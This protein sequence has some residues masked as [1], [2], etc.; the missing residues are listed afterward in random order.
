MRLTSPRE[1][2]RIFLRGVP[3]DRGDGRV[4]PST[5][6]APAAGFQHDAFDESRAGHLHPRRAPRRRDDRR[7]SKPCAADDVTGCERACDAGD[8]RQLPEP[9]LALRSRHR[10]AA[11][12]RRPR[13]V[14]FRPRVR[15]RRRAGLRESRTDVRAT[16]AAWAQRCKARAASL[17]RARVQRGQR[18]GVHEPWGHLRLRPRRRE[19]RGARRSRAM[20]RGC[21]GGHA[22]GC[23]NLGVMTSSAAS[24]WGR[25]RRAPS[26][27][28]RRACDGG[29][30]AG[31]TNLGRMCERGAGDLLCRSCARRGALPPVAASAATPTGAR[32]RRAEPRGDSSGPMQ[33]VTARLRAF[34]NTPG[35][36][37]ALASVGR[38]SKCTPSV[39][40]IGGA[41][42]A[43]HSPRR[44]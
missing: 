1:R 7:Y 10:P 41:R 25:T 23:A 2:G 5:S 37:R 36:P 19:R 33:A 26:R 42:P 16:A 40:A 31:C 17:Y 43:A 20:R 18:A 28:A 21:D 15:R 6:S 3:R 22:H 39:V 27:A 14:L 11:A 12:R 35:A 30:A 44:A 29:S 9:G 13:G 8:A 32:R 4:V 34:A 38:R 24:G